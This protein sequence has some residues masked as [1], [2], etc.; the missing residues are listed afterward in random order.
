[1]AISVDRFKLGEKKWILNYI[2][3]FGE[4]HGD[5]RNK[6]LERILMCIFCRKRHRLTNKHFI[7]LY[8]GDM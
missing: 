3:R 2:K 5:N 1:M 7:D 8:L 6:S 4:I